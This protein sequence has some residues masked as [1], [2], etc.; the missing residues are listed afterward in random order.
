M[1]EE[2]N[3]PQEQQI[4][5]IEVKNQPVKHQKGVAAQQDQQQEVEVAEEQNQQEVQQSEASEGQDQQG[6]SNEVRREILQSCG[7]GDIGVVDDLRVLPGEFP[8]PIMK[9]EK[10]EFSEKAEEQRIKNPI[11]EGKLF[12]IYGL[13]AQQQP[14]FP[15]PARSSELKPIDDQAQ[16]QQQVQGKSEGRQLRPRP[17]KAEP[18]R[19]TTVAAL[20]SLQRQHE[21]QQQQLE[22]QH[23]GW[24]SRPK[25]DNDTSVG[26][27]LRSGR[28]HQHQQP[29]KRG[30]GRPPK[31][32]GGGRLPQQQHINCG[33][34][35]KDSGG[36]VKATAA[37]FQEECSPQ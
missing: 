34:V 21:K 10:K 30:R 6:Q 27:L 12:D 37:I 15:C 3:E 29:A 31:L 17:P 33:Y 4:D 13:R 2:Q 19:G 25:P 7:D 22:C 35:I 32:Q 1:T 20:L 26:E 16:Q 18:T 24:S 28:Q 11:G 9:E 14:E 8:G 36:V 23:Q 5:V